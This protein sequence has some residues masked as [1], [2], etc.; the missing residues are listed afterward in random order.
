[1]RKIYLLLTLLIISLTSVWADTVT[2]GSGRTRNEAM[3][4]LKSYLNA[5]PFGH[6]AL[7]EGL[8]RLAALGENPSTADVRAVYAQAVAEAG[9]ELDENLYRVRVTMANVGVN[10]DNADK[11]LLLGV[12]NSENSNCGFKMYDTQA[13][14]SIWRFNI[15]SEGKYTIA[16]N[17]G[18]YIG[19]KENEY[20]PD[21]EKEIDLCPITYK[22]QMY[23]F[24]VAYAPNG[25]GVT[26]SVDGKYLSMDAD[27]NFSFVDEVTDFAV[28]KLS[29]AY[30]EKLDL[31][32]FSTDADPVYYTLDNESKGLM[33][34]EGSYLNCKALD[35]HSYW[36]FVD[37]GE[38]IGSFRLKNKKDNYGIAYTSAT[39]RIRAKQNVESS[40]ML[41]FMLE[42]NE[43]H[44][45]SISCHPI[46]HFTTYGYQTNHALMYDPGYDWVR[47][48]SPRF[49][50]NNIPLFTWNV[51]AADNGS[52]SEEDVINLKATLKQLY[53]YYKLQSPWCESF[54]N[55]VI[56]ELDAF[57]IS[58]YAS[59]DKALEALETY[60]K[61]T[62][63]QFFT[64]INKEAL[65]YNVK[66]SNVRRF[67]HA[68]VSA[69][70][71]Y[72]TTVGEGD[73]LTLNTVNKLE[74]NPGYWNIEA[75][76]GKN[77]AFRLRNQ[78]GVYLCNV[79]NNTT[80]AT[81]TNAEEAGLYCLLPYDSFIRIVNADL[82]GSG[83]NF[84]TNGNALT[85]YDYK[86]DGST[87][88][89]ESV[90][91]IPRVEGMPKLSDNTNKY[92]YLVRSA[93]NETDYLEF[94]T[95][96]IGLCHMPKSAY[97][98]CYFVPAN[99]GSDGVQ[100]VC[101]EYGTR[102]CYSPTSNYYYSRITGWDTNPNFNLYIVPNGTVPDGTVGAGQTCFSIS[103][104]YPSDG[105]T[106]IS[107]LS[108]DNSHPYYISCGLATDW[109]HTGWIFEETAAINHEEIFEQNVQNLLGQI[110]SY[111]KALPWAHDLI[112]ALREKV[113]NAKM[114]DYAEQ[115]PAAVNGL[116]ADYNSYIVQIEEQLEIE[117]EDAWVTISNVRRLGNKEA[118]A[119]LT[120]KNGYLNTSDA[121]TDAGK[122]QMKYHSN[123]RYNLINANG[124]YMG[125]LSDRVKATKDEAA[126]G[127]YALKLLN[128]YVCLVDRSDENNRSLNVNPSQG[129]ACVYNPADAGSRWIFAL[130][131]VTGI[132]ETLHDAA[133][134]GCEYFTPAGIKVSPERLTPGVYLRVQGNTTTKVLVK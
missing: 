65:G 110:E 74:R 46:D 8:S 123:G 86:D 115:T 127:K 122:W 132:E 92:L 47:G 87:W 11:P 58:K 29:R 18:Q 84:D 41:F 100:I 94:D 119:Y 113:E 75:V 2:D 61:K 12:E 54:L 14:V 125:E 62:A 89:F 34:V 19:Y 22:D 93:T 70:G 66:I 24:N 30:D 56:A 90:A 1:M 7:N 72:L 126:A 68:N 81:T 97:S 69:M 109:Q 112:E 85:G 6:R 120:A 10:K 38:K 33:T 48:S 57:D 51:A 50:M 96:G 129:D 17:V 13:N 5:S 15:A 59:A 52:G 35:D 102:L 16:C 103:Y 117:P 44:G 83:L 106:C 134:S 116:M 79:T 108:N 105:A 21:N 23:E 39:G 78:N 71:H 111:S 32:V 124:Q 26:F 114:T 99:D 76:N 4:N 88:S 128:G 91:L 63:D 80:V 45:W 133:L 82:K 77:N 130:T 98:Y 36:Y 73:A 49:N 67:Q 95:D 107:N 37:A 40:S 20:S 9:V 42:G 104:K 25:E 121:L 118:G 60:G 53:T 27:G 64:Q 101:E 31:P 3:S 131:S 43:A 55:K 28:W